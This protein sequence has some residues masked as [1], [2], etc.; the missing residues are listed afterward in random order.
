MPLS[1]LSYTSILGIASTAFI[2]AV[3]LIDGFSKREAPGSLWDPAQTSFLP[4]GVRE[5]GV[6]FGLFM[7]GF[8]GHAVIPSLARDMVD[9]SRFDEMINWAF[10]STVVQCE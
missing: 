8:S 2:V 3:V 6:S 9:P 10:A 5:L 7:A 1:L 4:S